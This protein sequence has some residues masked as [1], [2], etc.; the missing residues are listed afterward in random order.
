M[1][2]FVPF[3]LKQNMVL[4]WWCDSSPYKEYNGVIAA[5]SIRSG[6]STCFSISYM[7][8]A[9]TSFNQ[10]NFGLCGNTVGSFKRNVWWWLKP[11]CELRG[12]KVTAGD[13]TMNQQIVSYKGKE[14]YFYIFG[15]HHEGSQKLIQGITLQ[16]CLFDEVALM[17]ESFVNQA[18]GRCSEENKKLWFNCNPDSPGHFFKKNWI[19][20]CAELNILHLHFTMDD[21][22]SLSEKTKSWYKAQYVGIFFKRFVLGLWAVAQGAI[23]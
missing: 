20:R 7:M 9:M 12:M 8:W 23:Y 3:S 10:K 21:N 22:P 1:I 4:T 11:W 15:G 18:T 2:N 6:K 17:R 14:N 5:G 13:P 16:G 19:D